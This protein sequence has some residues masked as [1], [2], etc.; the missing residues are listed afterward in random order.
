MQKDLLVLGCN[1]VQKSFLFSYMFNTKCKAKH[2]S[3]WGPNTYILKYGLTV[4]KRV[5][6]EALR[7]PTFIFFRNTGQLYIVTPITTVKDPLLRKAMC[8]EWNH[9]R[10]NRMCDTKLK[11]GSRYCNWCLWQTNNLINLESIMDSV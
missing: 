5:M 2:V 8:T 4:N 11:K 10:G 9:W 3:E 6:V 7:I 1:N